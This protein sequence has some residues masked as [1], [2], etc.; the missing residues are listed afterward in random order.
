MNDRT[1]PFTALVQQMAP[2]SDNVASHLSARTAHELARTIV[3]AE[4]R[5]PRRRR[6]A[7]KV[8][9]AGLGL[10]LA[11]AGTAAAVQAL[12]SPKL[13]GQ[14]W[15][16]VP[17]EGATDVIGPTGDPVADCATWW[18]HRL[19]T[20]PPALRAYQDLS[21]QIQVVPADQPVPDG[22]RAL[23]GGVVQDP[24]QFQLNEA[25]LDSVGGLYAR[26]F[27]QAGATAKAREL[28][29]ASGFQDWPVRVDAASVGQWP[30]GHCWAAGAS[31]RTHEV[32]VQAVPPVDEGFTPQ[33]W[34]LARQLRQSL[35]QCWSM[36][37]ALARVQDAIAR[38]GLPAEAQRLTEVRQIPTT[39]A[40]CTSVHLGGGGSA[41]ITLRGPAG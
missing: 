26:C 25:L 9:A 10:A 19:G 4:P 11:A 17:G 15:C 40:R 35:T 37:T 28:V 39:G 3:A 33:W 27:D 2:A 38:S 29:T 21:S 23:P 36:Q 14:A 12:Q 18:R 31:P 6:R 13:Q 32:V 8:S 1:D 41:V 22:W 30:A 34:Q 20:E 24:E 7:L 16:N 5:A